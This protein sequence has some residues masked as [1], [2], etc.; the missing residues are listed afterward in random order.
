[1]A[2]SNLF[3]KYGQINF[4]VAGF[5]LHWRLFTTPAYLLVSLNIYLFLYSWHKAALTLHR[6]LMSNPDQINSD[7]V[8]R[9]RNNACEVS[10]YSCARQQR[11]V[12]QRGGPA[13]GYTVP[14]TFLH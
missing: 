7:T 8:Y 11:P 3:K 10:R 1:M 12:T 13:P 14:P 9:C 2:C 5:L 6:V 4:V